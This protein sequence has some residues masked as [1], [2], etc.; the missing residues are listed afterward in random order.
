ML[1]IK[2]LRKFAEYYEEVTGM[3]KCITDSL[4][5]MS[6]YS[7]LYR[8]SRVVQDSLTKSYTCMIEFFMTVAYGLKEPMNSPATSSISRKFKSKLTNSFSYA[9]NNIDI[10]LNAKLRSRLNRI[11]NDIIYEIS[12]L[13]LGA[14]SI[15][16]QKSADYWESSKREL[17]RGFKDQQIASAARDWH[18]VYDWLNAEEANFRMHLRHALDLRHA[19]TCNWIISHPGANAFISRQK[20]HMIWIDGKP[21]SGKTVMMAYIVDTVEKTLHH[22]V[23]KAKMAY[24]FCDNKTSN[25]SNSTALAVNRSWIQQLI[26][27]QNRDKKV[28]SIVMGAYNRRIASL[29]TLEELQN[30]VDELISYWVT[31]SSYVYLYVDALDESK[32]SR[33]ILQQI[34]QLIRTHTSSPFLKICFSSRPEG[35]I[36]N[37]LTHVE[38]I[39]MSPQAV[40]HDIAKVVPTCVQKIIKHHGIT[41]IA[42][43]EAIRQAL[44][45]SKNGLFIWTRIMTDFLLQLPTVSDVMAV[46]V[47]NPDELTEL[48]MSILDSIALKLS[49]Q[50]RRRELSKRVFS[51]L[52]CSLRPLSIDA[53]GEAVTNGVRDETTRASQVPAHFEKL[54][55]ELCGPFV[56]TVPLLVP[57]QHD[58]FCVQFVHLSVKE[59]FL[60][61][62]ETQDSRAEVSPESKDFFVEE[63]ITHAS[64][65]ERCLNYLS[66]T[67]FNSG[68]TLDWDPKLMGF[69][70]Y[71][72]LQ[73]ISHLS[74]SAEHGLSLLPKLENFR[75]I[76]QALTWL[77]HAKTIRSVDE[78]TSGNILILQSHLNK[79]LNDAV[80]RSQHSWLK[81]YLIDLLRRSQDAAKSLHGPNSLEYAESMHE[82]ACVYELK[83][84]IQRP[85]ELFHNCKS[86][87]EQVD[88][89]DNVRARMWGTV[90]SLIRIY[91][92]QGR[93]EEALD[94]YTDLNNRFSTPPIRDKQV[95]KVQETLALLQRSSGMLR[96]A[97]STYTSVISSWRALCGK[98]ST[99]TLRAIDGLASVHDML[100]RLPEAEAAFEQV[101]EAYSSMLDPLHTE[102]LRTLHNIAS[103]YEYQ[104]RFSQAEKIY[105]KAWEGRATVIGANNPGTLTTLHNLALVLEHQERLEEAKE[106]CVEVLEA[107][108]KA[109]PNPHSDIGRA[110]NSLGSVYMRL[111]KSASARQIL[112]A[113]LDTKT[114]T[115]REVHPSILVTKNAIACLEIYQGRY[116]EA[117]ILLESLHHACTQALG[118]DH[119]SV[120]SVAHNLG[121]VHS[122]LGNW[123]AAAASFQKSWSSRSN[124][125]GPNNVLT[126]RSMTNM[127]YVNR[128]R[129]SSE[130]SEI[131][132][133]ADDPLRILEN[134]NAAYESLSSE[135]EIS[136]LALDRTVVI[137][138]LAR[139][140][141]SK[142]NDIDAAALQEQV[143]QLK[144]AIQAKN[145]MH[146]I[147]SKEI[148]DSL[149]GC[150]GDLIFDMR[151]ERLRDVR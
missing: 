42:A 2:F 135:N 21:G 27:T 139:T 59:F 148:L 14:R 11:V 58:S 30:L 124:V 110:Q 23:D 29:A 71:S 36:D 131:I 46:L 64:I 138:N 104:C 98:E 83:G 28:V 149:D 61:H 25:E 118:E 103:V 109:L 99:N 106:L 73:W 88:P 134:A 45:K 76:P 43:I 142:G 66:S 92:I 143:K 20:S 136:A 75:E 22:H 97:E 17:H 40:D 81:D 62:G 44:L 15:H 31:C 63:K 112:G 108:T 151:P 3:I 128:K 60:T 126:L 9:A 69:H 147:L 114:Q 51:W 80:A 68:N 140:H 120:F 18:D 129:F 145:V 93:L 111:G 34:N 121:I 144:A 79:W 53:L 41:D 6:L 101:L 52:S 95:T 87:L 96:E 123:N 32:D 35:D 50:H 86:I 119:L 8:D 49:K 132:E 38:R 137:Y 19:D 85:A 84:E 94:L 90:A 130:P 105:R 78:S 115:L 82:V 55:V 77:S 89:S 91:R 107:R 70:Q 54:V 133:V 127:A 117:L 1:T 100:G 26:H 37:L 47:H 141:G 150:G 16:E 72:T 122:K 57:G 74:L 24:F 4:P 146:D 125:L 67:S 65:A 33:K 113:A 116:T 12:N 39:T 13:E 10:A 56:E 48:Y 7:E 102:N 5:R